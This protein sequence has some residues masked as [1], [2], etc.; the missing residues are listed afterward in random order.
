MASPIETPTPIPA[1][2]PTERPSLVSFLGVD[3]EVGAADE[4]VAAAVVA[5]DDEMDVSFALPVIS[6]SSLRK[7]PVWSAQQFVSSSQQ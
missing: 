2:A 7:T 5:D 1:F 4:A 6:P 3:V